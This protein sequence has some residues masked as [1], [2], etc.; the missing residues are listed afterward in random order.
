[1]QEEHEFWPSS[2]MQYSGTAN[3][4]PKNELKYRRIIIFVV[5]DSLDSYHITPVVMQ[6]NFQDDIGT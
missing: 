2:L 4:F 5:L 6:S 1:M 3:F